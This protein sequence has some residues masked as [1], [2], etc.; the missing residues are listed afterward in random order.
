MTKLE[1]IRTRA[2]QDAAFADALKAAKTQE[3]L[4]AALRD[5]GFDV[6]AD[7]LAAMQQQSGAAIFDEALDGVAGG[8]SSSKPAYPHPWHLYTH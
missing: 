7:E 4:L 3:A 8:G 5:A 2:A 6:S 1:S